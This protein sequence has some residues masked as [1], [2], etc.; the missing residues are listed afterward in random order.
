[1]VRHL[2]EPVSSGQAMTA[3]RAGSLGE[4]A[5][6]LVETVREVAAEG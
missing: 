4:I 2:V 3:A 5:G 1:M 6:Y